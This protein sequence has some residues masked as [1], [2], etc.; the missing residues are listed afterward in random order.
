MQAKEVNIM[1]EYLFNEVQLDV[2]DLM[3][4]GGAPAPLQHGT[5]RTDS[6]GN[7]YVR[8]T[9]IMENFFMPGRLISLE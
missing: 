3:A 8:S 9:G 5:Y 1:K 4:R 2:V 7:I 6:N